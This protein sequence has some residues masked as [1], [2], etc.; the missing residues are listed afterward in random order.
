MKHRMITITPE[1]YEKIETLK[2]LTSI[3]MSSIIELFLLHKQFEI[4]IKTIKQA[5]SDIFKK[6]VTTG[7]AGYNVLIDLKKK[8]KLT[9]KVILEHYF[10]EDEE[11]LLLE[12]I[13]Y[14]KISTTTKGE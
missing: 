9:Y 7:T 13:N 3:S 4:N 1:S 12:L 10:N 14:L 2:G 11:T 6:T 8:Y 5:N